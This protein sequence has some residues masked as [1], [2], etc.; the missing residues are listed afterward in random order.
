[1]NCQAKKE[2]SYIGISESDS[3]ENSD[4]SEDVTGYHA[5]IVTIEEVSEG[6]VS[7]EDNKEEVDMSESDSEDDESE[8]EAEFNMKIEFHKLYENWLELSR[9]KVSWVEEKFS[10]HVLNKRLN[11]EL[12]SEIE[13]NKALTLELT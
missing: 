13:K 9:E 11:E 12:N 8:E 2:K 6:E 7:G 4:G 1:M 10:L 5:F 3:D